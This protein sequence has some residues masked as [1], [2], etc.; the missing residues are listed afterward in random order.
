MAETAYDYI[1]VGAGSA[2]AAL[3]ARL[4]EDASITV[5]LLEAGSGRRS[6][7]S[8]MPSALAHAINDPTLNWAYQTEPEPFLNGRRVGHPR[9]KALGGSSAINGMMYVRGHAQDYDRWAQKG[10][11]GWA[12]ADVLPYFRRSE[13]FDQG[14][15]DYHGGDGPLNV[16][17]AG[18]TNPLSRAFVEAGRQAGYPVTDDVN[19]RQQEGFGRADRTTHR[20]RRW[21]TARAYLDP[22]RGRANLT[23]VAPAL[24]EKVVIEGRR[25]VGVVYH[26][27][28]GATT[29]RAN[30]E[31]I[32]S[33]GAINSPQVLWLSGIGPADALRALGIAVVADRPGVGGNLHDH[34]DLAFKQ[35][36][37]QPVSLHKDVQPLGKLMVGVRWFLFHDGLGATNHYEA[38]AFIRSRGGIEHPDLQLTFLPMAVGGDTIQ[39]AVSIGQHAWMTHADLM[40]PTSRGRLWLASA[41]PRDKPRFVINYLQTAEDM[42]TMVLAVK[43]IRELHGQKAFDPY[44]GIEISPGP[45]VQTD[46][47][48]KAWLRETVDTSYHPV[49]TCKMALE[50]DPSA[51]VDAECRV[52]GIEGLRVVDASIMPDVVSGNTNAPSIMIGEKA[53]DMIGGRPPLPRSQAPVWLHPERESRQR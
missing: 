5:L 11:R 43:L 17:S 50:S 26:G 45:G 31:V 9:G 21:T 3:A 8:D 41:D 2:G 10:C 37:T 39:S 36:C 34:P 18:M 20:G 13:C 42:A 44:R 27:A 49:G 47:E 23:I 38:E 1:V 19:G 40:R 15:D 52:Y 25:A 51:V 53:A 12:Y 33:G 4:T 24:T 29:A 14:A 30:R 7:K 28:G 32:V 16:T 48:I 46:R 22:N 6:W 35:A